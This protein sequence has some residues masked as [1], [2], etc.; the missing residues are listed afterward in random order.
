MAKTGLSLIEPGDFRPGPSFTEDNVTVTSFGGVIVALAEFEKGGELVVT[1]NDAETYKKAHTAGNRFEVRREDFIPDALWTGSDVLTVRFQ[2]VED[3]ATTFERVYRFTKNYIGEYQR[4]QQASYRRGRQREMLE[5]HQGRS[6]LR[7]ALEKIL[8]ETG[9]ESSYVDDVLVLQKLA[10]V[11]R[12]FLA[13]DQFDDV[14]DEQILATFFAEDAFDFVKKL[15]NRFWLAKVIWAAIQVQ[16]D[17]VR[18]EKFTHEVL[19]RA[20]FKLSADT[21]AR[22]AAF[23][24]LNT[25]LI[26]AVKVAEGVL[27]ISRSG[28]Q[29]V[30]NPVFWTSAGR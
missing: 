20:T 17:L 23:D 8:A 27:V 22:V 24:Q 7:G 13:L 30:E 29:L 25:E 4:H 14:T 3:G 19:V 28:Q 12:Q 1:A 21:K 5:T 9:A 15:P 16:G 26:T 2:M 10:G 6:A 18:F 11:A